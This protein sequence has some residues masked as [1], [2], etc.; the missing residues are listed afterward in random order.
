QRVGVDLLVHRVHRTIEWLERITR[1]RTDRA[2]GQQYCRSHCHNAIDVS[3]HLPFCPPSAALLNKYRLIRFSSTIADCV[4]RM[5]SPAASTSLSPPGSMPLYCSPSR[6]EVRI[7]S[8]LSFG[9]LYDDSS[10]YLTYARS[11]WSS[12]PID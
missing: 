10:C 1:I 12:K 8:E 3:V 6:Q 11:A 2:T 5:R 4:I 9:D 7:L